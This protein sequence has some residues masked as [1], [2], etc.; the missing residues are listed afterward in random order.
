MVEKSDKF[1]DKGKQAFKGLKSFVQDSLGDQSNAKTYA[2]LAYVPLIGPLV[3]LLFKKDVKLPKL[4][5]KNAA[6]LQTNFSLIWLLIWLLENFPL[7]SDLLKLFQFIPF[8]TSALMYVNSILLVFASV[9]GAWQGYQE[10][11]WFTPYLYQFFDKCLSR[12][13]FK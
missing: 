11:T 7:I 2:S 1:L 3:V 13:V 5:A 10:K 12:Y 6:Y 8:V 9:Y 4:H